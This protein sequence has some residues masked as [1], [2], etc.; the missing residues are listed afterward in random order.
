MSI[1]KVSEDLIFYREVVFNSLKRNNL[2]AM[3]KSPELSLAKLLHLHAFRNHL[4]NSNTNTIRNL[5]LQHFTIVGDIQKIASVSYFGSFFTVIVGIFMASKT[6]RAARL[7]NTESLFGIVSLIFL[8]PLSV[9]PVINKAL[10]V[11]KRKEMNANL[12]QMG[13]FANEIK[14]LDEFRGA[15]DMPKTLEVQKQELS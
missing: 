8:F 10:T 7:S 2:R 13:D 14:D 6:K 5:L 15:L 11:N 1:E 9:Y 12:K 4:Q 3:K